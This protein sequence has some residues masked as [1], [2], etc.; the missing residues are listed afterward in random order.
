MMKLLA[1]LSLLLTYIYAEEIAVDAKAITKAH[2]DLRKKYNSPA[3]KYSKELESAARTWATKLQQD[4]CAMVHSHGKVGPNGENLFWASAVKTANAKDASGSWI[5][6][7]R[8]KKVK[9]EAVVQAWY[10]E[11]QWY[12]YETN[13][14]EEGK[15]CG[16]FTQ[17]VWSTTT[18]LGCAAMACDDR[19]QVWVCEYAPAGNVSVR[20]TSGNVEKLRPY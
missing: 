9:E 18:E 11:V 17:V 12:D 4:G 15:V 6:H 14:C 16:H 19:S 7:S 3:L 8:L 1:I 5:W 10:D 13:S 2:N 20:E